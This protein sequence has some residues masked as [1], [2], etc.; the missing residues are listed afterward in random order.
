[1]NIKLD[2]S[3]VIITRG[4]TN[5]RREYQVQYVTLQEEELCVNVNSGGTCTIPYG[6]EGLQ[7]KTTRQEEEAVC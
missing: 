3:E 6:M 2:G 7:Y 1:M 4:T 5:K